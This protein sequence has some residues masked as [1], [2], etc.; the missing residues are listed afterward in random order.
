[1]VRAPRAELV[2]AVHM[3]GVVSESVGGRPVSLLIEASGIRLTSQAQE[4]G[5]AAA[6]V[7]ADLG[8][9]PMHIALNSRFLLDALS[10]FDVERVE[11]RLTDSVAPAVIRGIGA[12]SCTCVVM[13]VRLAAPPKTMATSEAA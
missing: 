3:V 8:G 13:P 7:E 4:I 2:R 11:M 6:E 9:K 5:E 10:A 12:E 1:V